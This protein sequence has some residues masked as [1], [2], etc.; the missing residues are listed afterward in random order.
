MISF[1]GNDYPTPDGTCLRDYI[2]V[3]DL[4]EG[5]VKALEKLAEDPG[6]VVYNL[7]TGRPYSVLEV[8][9]A[10]ERASGQKIPYDI[11]D[12]RPGD[13]PI[14]YADPSKANRELDW[15]ARYTLEEM[16]VDDWNWQS[17]N[18]NGYD[19]I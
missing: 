12:R 13:L 7:G 11:L 10:F 3:V 1:W 18:P 4:A 19:E 14:S 16:C 15:K 17:N 6:A 8:V 2:H 5:H 9:H